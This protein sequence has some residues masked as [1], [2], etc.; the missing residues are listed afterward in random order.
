MIDT[1]L[2]SSQN[3]ALRVDGAGIELVQQSRERVRRKIRGGGDAVLQTSLEI[4]RSNA[5][6][7]SWRRLEGDWEVIKDRVK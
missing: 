1:S 4:L 6:W 5:I 7:I 3:I 2:D